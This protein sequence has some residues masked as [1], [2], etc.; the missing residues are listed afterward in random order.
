M[1]FILLT[2]FSLLV[3]LH[4]FC[5]DD[6]VDSLKIKTT[7]I[8]LDLPDTILPVIKKLSSLIVI[9]S[10]FDSTS[11]GFYKGLLD[12]NYSITAGANSANEIGSFIRHYLQLS[13]VDSSSAPGIVIVLKKLWLTNE[14]AEDGEKK[15]EKNDDVW[16]SG[17]IA[18]FE[19]YLSNGDTYIPFYRFDTSYASAKKISLFA[20]DYIRDVLIL[21]LQKLITADFKNIIS[22][23]K[24]MSLNEIIA[25]SKQQLNVPIITAK[26]YQRGVYKTFEEFK[27]NTPSIVNYEI[28]NDKLTDILF[29]RDDKGEYPVR[30][31]WGFCD[32]SRL[33]INSA[34]NYFQLIKRQNTFITSGVKSLSRNRHVKAGNVIFLGVLAG[35]VGKANKNIS[36]GLNLRPYELDMDSGE[37][38]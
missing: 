1:K 3:F 2:N 5:Q 26:S 25:Y 10:R 22:A 24:K 15:S 21:S 27:M 23:R 4:C 30:N 31:V 6:K 28:K 11:F 14:F 12:K 20:K 16:L 7:V 29:V 18:K 13:T 8:T 38:Y 36:Y 35:G 32:G 34:N 17:V 33:Y 19:F 9:D 37:L